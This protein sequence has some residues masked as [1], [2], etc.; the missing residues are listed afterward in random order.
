MRCPAIEGIETG[1]NASR[2]RFRQGRVECVAPLLRG[3]KQTWQGLHSPFQYPCGRMRC[4][5][6][7]GIE[8]F[9]FAAC[10]GEGYVRVECVAPLLRGLKHRRYKSLYG[11]TR[12]SVECVAPLLRGLKP[13]QFNFQCTFGNLSRMRCPAIEG[14]E[15]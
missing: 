7:E 12:Y 2:A 15:T 13:W 4:P 9:L 3:L 5:A 1:P 11:S 8:T 14:I 6:I 10:Q